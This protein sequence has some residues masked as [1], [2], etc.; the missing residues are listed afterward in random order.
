MTKLG[1]GLEEKFPRVIKAN[2]LLQQ[3]I[4]TG[5]LDPFILDRI[6]A[7]LDSVSV[8]FEKIAEPHMKKIMMLMEEIPRNDYGR[9]EFIEELVKPI[10]ELKATGGVF[11][12][13]VIA[14]VSGMVLGILENV[15]KLDDD[16]LDIIK[17]HNR[18]INTIIKTSI[19]TVDDRRAIEI[20]AEIK[21]ACMRYYNRNR[22][23]MG[24]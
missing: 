9:E 11:N 18:A 14:N 19:K 3:K 15:R 7:Y 6:Q 12:E 16:M 20:L 8:D 13:P 4:G 17:V 2:N 24:L 22:T 23:A 10:M 1:S 21:H 5:K